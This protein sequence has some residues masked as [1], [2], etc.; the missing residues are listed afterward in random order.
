M[1]RKYNVVGSFRFALN[2]LKTAFVK[3]PN[4]RIHSMMAISAIILAMLLDFSI[5]EWVVVVFTI[6]LVLIFE[7]LNTAIEALTNLFSP[8]ISEYAKIAKDVTAASVLITAVNAVV[9]G[10]LLYLPKVI[11]LL[12]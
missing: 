6:S 10:L 7:L 8:E 5:A 9:V 2:G 4:F 11:A 1:S 3:E 12:N